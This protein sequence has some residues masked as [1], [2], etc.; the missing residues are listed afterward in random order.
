MAIIRVIF[1][2]VLFSLPAVSAYSA[3]Q[4]VKMADVIAKI[5][6]ELESVPNID[7]IRETMKENDKIYV[8]WQNAGIKRSMIADMAYKGLLS[9]LNSIMDAKAKES[10]K[11]VEMTLSST[12][13]G[14]ACEKNYSLEIAEGETI[15]LCTR[16]EGEKSY[17]WDR[18]TKKYMQKRDKINT[19]IWFEQSPGYDRFIE[20][21][22]E[23]HF[24]G[25]ENLQYIF[26]I[27]ENENDH[28]RAYTENV[29]SHFKIG[30]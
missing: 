2:S 18:Q 9:K 16:D 19:L 29:N 6:E 27:M 28:I 12:R 1:L 7:M 23:E 21:Q 17:F 11:K 10:G 20:I 15:A 5:R 22:Y 8:A 26:D 3:A 24:D 13:K 14:Y 30:P 4:I 25:K